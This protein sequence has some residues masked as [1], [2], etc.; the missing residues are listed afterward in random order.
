MQRAYT[1]Q[2]AYYRNVFRFTTYEG[3]AES[4]QPF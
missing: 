3:C 2:R 1:E 4:I